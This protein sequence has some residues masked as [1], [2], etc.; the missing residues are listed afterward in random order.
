ML[1]FA[2]NFLVGFLLHLIWISAQYLVLNGNF[3]TTSMENTKACHSFFHYF[4]F[5]LC[6]AYFYLFW[7][8]YKF[9]NLFK[10]LI[11]YFIYVF[12]FNLQS[13]CFTCLGELWSF[14]FAHLKHIVRCQFIL[15]TH[16]ISVSEWTNGL[17]K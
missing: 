10:N 16:C 5:L 13:M 12:I 9:M 14:K 3:L 4:S 15:S 11:M 2:W 6:H 7:H 1:P 8:I 17:M